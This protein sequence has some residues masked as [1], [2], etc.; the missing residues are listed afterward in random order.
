MLIW[1]NAIVRLCAR[2]H[3]NS[4]HIV[5]SSLIRTLRARLLSLRSVVPSRH[6]V[7][8]LQTLHFRIS[9]RSI[10]FPKKQRRKNCKQGNYGLHRKKRG[11]CMLL[12]TPQ[13]TG[14]R[15]HPFNAT[16]V[17]ASFCNQWASSRN[18]GGSICFFVRKCK[19]IAICLDIYG[20]G[21]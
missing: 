11:V 5:P 3:E 1:L 14:R 2:L 18:A 10:I 16:S 17:A 8:I 6:L 21:N 19:K 15:P 13:R 9:L 20:G 7:L 12:Q 4:R